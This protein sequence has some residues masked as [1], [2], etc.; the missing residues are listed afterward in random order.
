MVDFILEFGSVVVD[1]KVGA[2]SAKLHVAAAVKE[3]C[4]QVTAHG[5][6]VGKKVVIPL[7]QV[8]WLMANPQM[9]QRTQVTR[10]FEVLACD[11]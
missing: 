4:V 6:A 7:G 9:H 5:R 1:V 2:V 3:V 10:W 11:V 8:A